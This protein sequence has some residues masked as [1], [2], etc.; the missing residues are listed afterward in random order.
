MGS[1]QNVFLRFGVW[2]S[3][4][5][6]AVQRVLFFSDQ[7]TNLPYFLCSITVLDIVFVVF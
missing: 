4:T 2:C 7:S 6:I 5:H 3:D 1:T